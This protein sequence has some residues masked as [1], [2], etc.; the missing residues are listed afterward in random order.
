MGCLFGN[1]ISVN[2]LDTQY[3]YINPFTYDQNTCLGGKV[4][5][6]G[7]LFEITISVNQIV[8][9]ILCLNIISKVRHMITQVENDQNKKFMRKA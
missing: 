9:K 8:L 6:E 5:L 7:G 3:T 2:P 4:S 1:A